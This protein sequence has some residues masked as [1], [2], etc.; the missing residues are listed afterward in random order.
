MAG[1][2]ILETCLY[3]NDLVK[4]EQF[5]HDVLGLEVVNRQ[6]GRHIFFRCGRSMLLVFDPESSR[7]PNS[8]VPTHGTDG[9]GHL[10]FSVALENQ[11]AEWEQHLRTHNVI[12][13]KRITWPGGGQSV[14]VRD[15]AGNS[16]EL[17]CSSIW[18]VL[19]PTIHAD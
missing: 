2:E 19:S 14:Y 1:L 6:D 7:K 13:E 16:I 18:R 15:P 12:I 3:A 8:D 17:T 9:A 5:Y 10:A 4:A 11:L